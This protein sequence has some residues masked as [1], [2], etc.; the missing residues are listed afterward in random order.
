MPKNIL[1]T[2]ALATTLAL[3]VLGAALAQAQGQNAPP[4]PTRASAPLKGSIVV[5]SSK[6]EKEAEYLRLARITP[7]QAAAAAQKAVPG[8]VLKVELDEED[9]FLVYEVEIGNSEVRIDAGTG[10]VLRV[11][12]DDHD[13]APVQGSVLVPLRQPGQAKLSKEQRQAEY[14]R[15]ARITMQQAA[16]AA[17]A[18]VPGPVTEVKLTT[19]DRSLVYEVKVGGQEVLVDAGNGQVLR[20]EADD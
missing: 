11:K 2:A 3:S 19:K 9:G 10:Q 14:A 6:Q 18:R 4:A 7:Q 12:Q 13:E 5:P 1:I 16:A 17:Q 8:T 15:L 20:A